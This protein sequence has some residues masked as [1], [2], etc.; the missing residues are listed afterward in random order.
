MNKWTRRDV[1][2]AAAALGISPGA[3]K[4]AESTMQTKVIPATDEPLPVI[5]LGT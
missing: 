1:L 4:A 3:L 5:G 2:A